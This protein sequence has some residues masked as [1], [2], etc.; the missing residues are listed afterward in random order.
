[1]SCDPVEIIRK[2]VLNL[3]KS[4]LVL[5]VHLK[6]KFCCRIRS[7]WLTGSKKVD[8]KCACTLIKFAFTPNENYYCKILFSK[9]MSMI[10]TKGGRGKAFQV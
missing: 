6:D 9:C 3:L 2:V 1:M 8:N 5:L 7:I 4:K 10:S